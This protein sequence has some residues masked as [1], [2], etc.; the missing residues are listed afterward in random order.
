MAQ[1]K[2]AL[3]IF[4]EGYLDVSPTL[5]ALVNFFSGN[6]FD[7][8]VVLGGE[9]SKESSTQ[10][11]RILNIDTATS[12]SRLL[13][14]LANSKIISRIFPGL[15]NKI[16]Q[17]VYAKRL[18]KFS[19]EVGFIERE[20]DVAVSVDA[21]GLYA[22]SQSGLK[23]KKHVYLSFEIL[24]VQGAAYGFDHRVKENEK[25]AL[26]NDIDL[27]LVQDKY[28]KAFLER[29]LGFELDRYVFLPNS[30][31]RSVKP[32]LTK[33]NYFHDLFGLDRGEK[34]VL[35]AGMI[36]ESVCSLDIAK[37]IAS[38]KVGLAVK[39]VFHERIYIQGNAA[40]YRRVA[41]A[42]GGRVLLS[43]K[44]V[45]YSEI[46]SIFSSADIGLAI[47]SAA[48]GDNFGLIGSASGKLFQYIKY[49]LPVIASDL[50]GLKELVE[51]NQLGVVVQSADEVPEAID[52]ILSNYSYYSSN[53]RKAFEDK[54]NMDLYLQDVFNRISA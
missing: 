35:S 6:G 30:V 18:E 4:W 25:R 21:T 8:L 52:R 14:G 37:A 19:E 53:A 17:Q 42:G 49:G 34:I 20:F 46:D 47:Y 32:V 26:R 41:E 11:R 22:F 13:I 45:P 28:R 29:T 10:S 23:A 54:L 3:F 44:P 15:S 33:G 24:E 1:N 48:A 31:P 43:L 27:V 16:N 51:G 9:G 7:T 12:G 38:S 36:S 50:P 5:I 40:Y 2:T 39:T